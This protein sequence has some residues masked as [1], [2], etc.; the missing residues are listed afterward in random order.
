MPLPGEAEECY[1]KIKSH[2]EER[3]KSIPSIFR[4]DGIRKKIKTHFFQ[5]MKK[6]LESQLKKVLGEESRKFRFKKLNQ[7]TIASINLKVNSDLLQKTVFEV[8][9]ADSEDNSSL[10]LKLKENL[11]EEFL[12]FP[13]HILYDDYLKGKQFLRDFKKIERKINSICEFEDEEDRPVI[14]LYLKVYKEFSENFIHYFMNTSPNQ[15]SSLHNRRPNKCFTEYEYVSVSEEG[16]SDA[17]DKL[18][19]RIWI[20]IWILSENF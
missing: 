14:L 19:I 16:V 3:K 8:Y 6:L 10:I 4:K 15:R 7:N 5:W 9:S 2:F 13:L 12:N 18:W 1:T 11:N 17:E 20:W